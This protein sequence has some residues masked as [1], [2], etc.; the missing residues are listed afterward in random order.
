MTTAFG[1]EIGRLDAGRR[2]DA[3]V[4]D[5]DSATYPYQDPEIAPLD[6]MIYRAKTKDVHV[7]MI[8]GEVVYKDGTFTRIE[9]DE[10]LAQIAEALAKPRDEDEEGRLWLRDIVFADVEAFYDGYIKATAMRDPFYPS[11]SRN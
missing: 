3:V 10:I 6:A 11:S 2:F 1:A 4:L 5:Y 8:D 9:R 7:V